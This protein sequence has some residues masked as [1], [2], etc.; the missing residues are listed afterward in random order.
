MKHVLNN[1]NFIQNKINGISKTV[2]LI[3]V[4]KNK[5][6]DYIQ[7]LLQINHFDYGENIIQEANNKWHSLLLSNKQIRLHLVGRIQSNKAKQAFNLFEYIHSLDSEKLAKIFSNL[8]KEHAIKKKYF[9]QVNI[10]SEE[11]KAGISLDKLSDFS[12]LCKN[13]LNLNILGFM[14][15]PPINEDPKK[16]FTKLFEL[17]GHYKYKEL[18]MGMSSDY[19]EAIRCGSTYVR[20]GSAIFN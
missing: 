4:T 6:F 13:Q 3:A 20:I 10:G 16:Y 18:S 17:N 11:Q 19:E 12:N 5:S 7:P 15:I 9:I 14:C 1:F 8:E 2:K